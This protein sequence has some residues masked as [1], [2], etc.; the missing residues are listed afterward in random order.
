M[1]KSFLFLIGLAGL[2]A[3]LAAD[4]IIS[5]EAGAPPVGQISYHYDDCC[6]HHYDN[7]CEHHFDPCCAHEHD[8]CEFWHGG[9]R[10]W[11]GFYVGAFIGY[12]FGENTSFFGVSNLKPRGWLGGGELGWNYQFCSWVVGIEADI[13][14]TDIRES[15]FF[16]EVA[17]QYVG[18]VRG[19]IGYDWCDNL[20]YV[21]G[22]FAYGRTKYELLEA[23]SITKSRSGWTVGAG[24]ERKLGCNW[25]VK[26]E[27]LYYHLKKFDDAITSINW[28]TAAHTVRLGVNY[29]F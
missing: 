9:N 6:E 1:K 15:V 4:Q 11:G 29:H 28:K 26:L 24:L 23:G 21:T 19:R 7:C 18:T 10:E 17:T 3:P 27:Y 22:G 2:T 8:C 13:A 16:S 25:S 20:L 12:G 5:T 14:A